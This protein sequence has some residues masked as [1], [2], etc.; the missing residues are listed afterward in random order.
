M[1][2][3]QTSQR[4]CSAEIKIQAVKNCDA[5]CQALYTHRW[6]WTQRVSWFAR[7]HHIA[8]KKSSWYSTDSKVHVTWDSKTMITTQRKWKN[9][10]HDQIISY[11]KGHI[12]TSY[13]NM[14][15]VFNIK[16]NWKT[17]DNYLYIYLYIRI[18]WGQQFKTCDTI[19]DIL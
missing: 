3:N 9:I 14:K 10:L 15:N 4:V 1:Q 2:K 11:W 19:Q 17:K 5:L 16:S 6:E 12:K 7:G 13:S 18:V 8:T